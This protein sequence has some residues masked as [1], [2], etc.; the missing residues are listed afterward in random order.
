MYSPI[1]T[2]QCATSSVANDV[3]GGIQVGEAGIGSGTHAA[4]WTG[5]A[6][7]FVDMN[8]PGAGGSRLRGVDG[9]FQVGEAFVG[10]GA[11][12]KAASGQALRPAS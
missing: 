1:C 5:T 7:S 4:L 12:Y 3:D 2:Q 10:P 11:S 9:G 8:P 6:A